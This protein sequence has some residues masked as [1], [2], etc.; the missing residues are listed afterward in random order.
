MRGD[1]RALL[2]LWGIPERMES[3]ALRVD[4]ER[5]RIGRCHRRPAGG[6]VKLI[7]ENCLARPGHINGALAGETRAGP[8]PER[9]ADFLAEPL[10]APWH[11]HGFRRRYLT[12]ACEIGRAHV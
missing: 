6:I 12:T 4:G 7:Q 5:G 11:I 1:E 9:A 3:Q 8:M 10:V 2:H